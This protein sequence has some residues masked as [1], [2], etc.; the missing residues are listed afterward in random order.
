MALRTFTHSG[1][2]GDIIYSL[3]TIKVFGGGDLLLYDDSAKSAHG[4]TEEKVERLRPLLEHQPYINKVFWSEEG[5]DSPLNGF[6]NHVHSQGNLADSH[7]A[8]EGIGW[9]AR[10]KRWIDIDY[11]V[12]T[13][14]VVIH[15]STRYPNPRFPWTEIV[16]K[17]KGQIG[18][19][20]FPLEHSIFCDQFGEVDLIEANDFMQLARVIAGSKLFIGN[21]S[22]PCAVAHGM[23]HRM[24]MEVCPWNDGTSHHCIFQRMDCLLGWDEK[25][26]L[27][28]LE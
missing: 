22:S 3:P 13:Y 14:P 11:S 28:C 4:M 7:L 10:A 17:Y 26:E 1:D 20:G 2:L 15:R 24:I 8:T 9:R 5:R 16:A 18:Y 25:I 12:E 19:V 27:P 21:Q 23:K 6:R